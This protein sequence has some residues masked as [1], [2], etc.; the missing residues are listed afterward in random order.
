MFFLPPSPSN[1]AASNTARLLVTYLT[2]HR[3]IEDYSE[4]WGWSHAVLPTWHD[5]AL[6]DYVSC[7][8]VFLLKKKLFSVAATCGWVIASR[9]FE[10]TFHFY[11]QN[12]ESMNWLITSSMKAVLFS[13][14]GGRNYRTTG[15]KNPEDITI[16]LYLKCKR[17]GNL[18]QYYVSILNSKNSAA[19][20][21]GSLSCW[22][23]TA[24]PG[25]QNVI[26]CDCTVM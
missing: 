15:R 9:C 7:K 8:S 25:R 18:V 19:F 5:T 23:I 21:V 12:D 6:K 10:G 24:R 1:H 22:N 3:K 2:S 13:E 14:T 26:Y 16:L 20:K 11:F 17:N 4:R